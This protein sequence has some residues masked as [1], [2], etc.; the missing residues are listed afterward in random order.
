M[1]AHY[2]RAEARAWRQEKALTRMRNGIRERLSQQPMREASQ[3]TLDRRRT[4]VGARLGRQARGSR[5]IDEGHRGGQR[6]R[7]I[8]L[9]NAGQRR[10]SRRRYRGSIR[11]AARGLA[12]RRK[13]LRCSILTTTARGLVL[14]AHGRP[15]PSGEEAY[16]EAQQREEST[17]HAPPRI[18]LG[19]VSRKRRCFRERR[20]GSRIDHASWDC[21]RRPGRRTREEPVML[22]RTCEPAVGYRRKS[23]RRR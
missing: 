18:S 2:E 23:S 11:F 21:L 5:A 8:E 12:D 19:L 6:H 14:R 16:Q 22:G 17:S 7:Y 1:T 20:D 9:R 3:A 13:V 4:S 15:S 10:G